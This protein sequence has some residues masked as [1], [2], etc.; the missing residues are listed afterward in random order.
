MGLP[1]WS[2]RY[3]HQAKVKALDVDALRQGLPGALKGEAQLVAKG[4]APEHGRDGYVKYHFEDELG[5][6]HLGV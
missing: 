6:A 2:R 4:E 5:R 1:D 3:A